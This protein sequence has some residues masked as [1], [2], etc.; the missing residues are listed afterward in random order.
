VDLAA[1]ARMS[2]GLALPAVRAGSFMSTPLAVEDLGNA[3]CPVAGSGDE[4]DFKPVPPVPA[5]T[6]QAFK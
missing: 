1:Q 6:P 3:G 4:P 2:W 5:D